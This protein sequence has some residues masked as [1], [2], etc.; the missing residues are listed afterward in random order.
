MLS[1]IV[2]IIVVMASLSLRVLSGAAYIADKSTKLVGRS[3]NK[4]LS[5]AGKA[6]NTGAKVAR[7][8]LRWVRRGLDL[9]AALFVPIIAVEVAV[10]VVLATAIIGGLGYFYLDYKNIGK[11]AVAA[12]SAQAQAENSNNLNLD[13]LSS[14]AGLRGTSNPGI[15]DDEWNK[16]TNVQKAYVNT[17][18][19]FVAED[20][21]Y[22]SQGAGAGGYD[23]SSFITDTFLIATG[24]S[25]A[26]KKIDNLDYKELFNNR[27]QYTRRSLNAKGYGTVITNTNGIM[28]AHGANAKVYLG[29]WN[30]AET[31]AK[32][33]PG[34]VLVD[35]QHTEMYLGH[36]RSDGKIMQIAFHMHSPQVIYGKDIDMK[37]LRKDAGIVPENDLRRAYRV[38][39]LTNLVS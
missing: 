31:R 11:A 26:G 13:G 30:S 22:Y 37:N 9:V 28:A 20:K 27:A 29:M 16:L 36:R 1:L 24:Y 32:M 2:F 10:S 19:A 8:S 14:A 17:A 35:S 23:C 3:K 38:Y 21:L 7:F 4:A 12:T 18:I 25:Y 39:R 6:A 34:D 15:R 5:I 33:L